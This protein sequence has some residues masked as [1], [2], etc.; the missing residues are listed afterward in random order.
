MIQNITKCKKVVFY[1]LIFYIGAFSISATFFAFSIQNSLLDLLKTSVKIYLGYNNENNTDYRPLKF[2]EYYYNQTY[3]EALNLNINLFSILNTIGNIPLKAWGFSISYFFFSCFSAIS[4][5][6]LYYIGNDEKELLNPKISTYDLLYTLLAYIFLFFGSGCSSLMSQQII[7]EYYFKFQ[8]ALKQNKNK[9]MGE[10]N[11]ETDIL[12][13]FENEN[14]SIINSLNV[15]LNE[16]DFEKKEENPINIMFIFLFFGFLNVFGFYFSYGNKIMSIERE[17]NQYTGNKNEYYFSQDIFIIIILIIDTII[18]NIIF[19]AAFTKNAC[20]C[21]RKNKN[22][23]N[24]DQYDVYKICGYTVYSETI[25]NN[26]NQNNNCCKVT[27]KCIKNCCDNSIC[28]IFES[29]EKKCECCCYCCFDFS[30][31]DF[32]SDEV[33]FC[34]IYRTERKCYW[35]NEFFSDKIQK[36]MVP[37]VFIYFILKLTT[38]DLNEQYKNN[39]KVFDN[40][41]DRNYWFEILRIMAI[42]VWFF[43]A[44]IYITYSFSILSRHISSQYSNENKNKISQGKNA[45]NSIFGILLFNSIFSLY[46]SLRSKRKSQIYFLKIIKIFYYLYL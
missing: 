3:S 24:E 7:I 45:L 32:E 4:F 29:D 43:I 27:C 38:I 36:E 44:F 26:N 9:I 8:K 31:N 17:F 25:K 40:N 15:K 22:L 14:Q 6:M 2:H 16:K 5:L 34:Y 18:F 42:Y 1:I 37:Y 13:N 39:I 19:I 21:N 10:Q 28:S 33:S 23:E 35:I 30:E 46:L 11:K 12:I 20:R 41:I